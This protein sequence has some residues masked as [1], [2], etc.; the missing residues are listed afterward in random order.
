LLDEIGEMP[1]ELQAKLLHV[2]QDQQF[3]RLGG[4][5]SVRVDVRILATTNINVPE[6]IANRQ[7]RE[8]LYY[9]LNAF[10]IQ[11]PPLRQRKEEISVLLRQ[12]MNRFADGFGR[13]PLPISQKM[14][15]A[16]VNYDWPG[17]LRELSNFVKRYLILGD[18]AAAVQELPAG[19]AANSSQSDS[20]TISLPAHSVESNVGASGLKSLVRGVKGEAEIQAISQ[21]L[22][23]T[24]WNRK[25]AARLLG[26][27]YK[28]LL[29]KIRQYNL[30]ERDGS[31][32]QQKRF[33]AK[34]H[35]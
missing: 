18:E 1:T 22:E 4:R 12:F 27:S 35:T 30:A 16:C 3:S 9:R 14:Q 6:A 21:V 7:F 5:A 29:Y 15:Q 13:A 34:L 32:F 23:Q 10:T 8:D 31:Q 24:K 11:M 20:S 2:I 17:N 25:E 33:S 19:S 28:A 26:I